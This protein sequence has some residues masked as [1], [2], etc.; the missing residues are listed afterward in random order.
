MCVC[1]KPPVRPRPTRSRLRFAPYHYHRTTRLVA[2]GYGELCPVDPRSNAEAW[3]RN[4]RVQFIITRTRVDGRTTAVVG[5]P[6]GRQYVPASV[7][8]PARS[9]Q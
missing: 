7:G 1:A 2:A 4:R 5:C 8:A 3:A 6:R 9:D